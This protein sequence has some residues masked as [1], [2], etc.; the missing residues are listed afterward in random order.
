[1]EKDEKV[2]IFAKLQSDGKKVIS[3]AKDD[4]LNSDIEKQINEADELMQLLSSDINDAN[5]SLARSISAVNHLESQSKQLSDWTII[6]NQRFEEIQ[7]DS[8][9]D[10][11]NDLKIDFNSKF[12]VLQFCLVS[13]MKSFF[14]KII[15]II[16][17]KI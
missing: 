1:M 13:I 7:N 8:D 15:Y 2:E 4:S 11:D 3:S 12:Q 16:N 9:S 17:I 10:N 14:I 5:Q 6:K